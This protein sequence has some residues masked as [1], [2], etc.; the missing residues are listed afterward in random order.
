M[1]DLL[2]RILNALDNLYTIKEIVKVY[3]ILVFKLDKLIYKFK[4]LFQKDL[5]FLLKIQ[6]I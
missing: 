2:L 3:L 4:T 6:T 1:A 5:R